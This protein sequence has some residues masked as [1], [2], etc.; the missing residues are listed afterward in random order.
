MSPE[1]G[2]EVTLIAPVAPGEVVEADTAETGAVSE[3]EREAATTE[4]ASLANIQ[5]KPHKPPETQAE[6][7]EKS[8]WVEIEL[9][10]D[11]DEPVPG[12]RYRVTLPDGS[13]DEGTLDARGFARVA[14]FEPG[15]CKVEFPDFDAEVWDKA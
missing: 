11:N 6:K 1:A 8:S 10:D 13:V 14:G 9:V 15:E 4:K 12:A 5:V 3:T 2:T 7:E